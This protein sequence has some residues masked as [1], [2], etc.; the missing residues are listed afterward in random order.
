MKTINFNH[1]DIEKT[2][3]S[4]PDIDQT[5]TTKPRNQREDLIEQI[6]AQCTFRKPGDD[7][8]LARLLAITANTCSWSC[9]DLHALLRKREDPTIRNYTRFVWWSAKVKKKQ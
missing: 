7:R 2:K 8:K 9:T 1:I 3:T 4:K 5:P 6:V